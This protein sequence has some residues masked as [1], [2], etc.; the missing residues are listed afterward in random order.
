ILGLL[1]V[2]SMVVSLAA[3]GGT[4]APQPTTAP[5][6]TAVAEQPT[7][8]PPEPTEVPPTEVPPTEVPPTE[9]PPTEAPPEPTELRIG[10]SADVESMDPFFVNQAA[11]WSVVHAL[12]DH[13]VERDF[14]GNIV[15]GLA[16]SWTIVDTATLE[17]VLREGVTFHNGEPFTADSVKFSVERM[18]AEEEAPNQGKFTAIDAV[19]VVDDY[20]VRLLLNRPDGTL[21][22]SLTS[23]LAM[24][25]PQYFEEVG[26]EGFAAAPVGT[27]PFSFVEWVPDDHVTLVANENYWDG[28]YK[29]KPMVDTVV[30]RPIPEAATRAAELEAGGVDIIQD[31]LPDQMDDLEEVGLVVIPDEAFQLQYIFFITDDE[32]LPTYDVKVRQALNYAVDVDAIIENLL[33][34][35]GSR[36][37]SPIGPGYLGYNPDVEPYPY[38]P[39]M[40]K[41]LLAEAGYADG[42]ETT[43]DATATEKGD[44]IE[45]VIG[46]LADVG[47]TATLQEFELG[48]FNQNWM[49][50]TQSMLW[51]AR[52]GNTPDPQSIELFA[53]CNGWITRYCN[54]DV[55]MHLEAARDTLDQDERAEHYAAASQLMHDDPLA[56]YM[57]TAAQIY[58]LSSGVENFQP[59]PLLA[60]I[61]S[62]I[63]VSE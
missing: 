55:T 31:V 52:W 53:S 42:F 56:I 59:S 13:L 22:D 54:E 15:P 38:D 20:T 32:T 45:A 44:L 18:L 62:G 50:H 12:F 47:V 30:F 29:G 51:A 6:P 36:I 9:P 1:V 4:E 7:E 14:D 25:P 49:D 5:E 46:Y 24:L 48:Q 28:S 43:I 2:L 3:C 41:D 39:Q 57:N 23:R 19:E 33:G 63:S 16:L 11:G 27:G 40:A 10:I 26:A 61:V 8:A 35:L 17:F 60:I 37:A 21:F 58:G 34:G